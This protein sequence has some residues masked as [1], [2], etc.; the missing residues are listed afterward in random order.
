VTVS[1]LGPAKRLRNLD[2]GEVVEGKDAA[3]KSS[4]HTPR[5]TEFHIEVA[6]HSFIAF[7]E[8]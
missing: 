6:P 8:E 4:A 3:N 7:A 1:T 2:N 5:W